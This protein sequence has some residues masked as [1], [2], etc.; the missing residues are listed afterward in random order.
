MKM[1]VTSLVSFALVAGLMS[2]QSDAILLKLSATGDVTLKQEAKGHENP[3]ATY[4]YLVET[5]V[6][7][8]DNQV[9]SSTGSTIVHPSSFYIGTYQ[10]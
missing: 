3:G 7:D 9:V 6:T 4:K 10:S 1:F 8:I 5:T 2:A